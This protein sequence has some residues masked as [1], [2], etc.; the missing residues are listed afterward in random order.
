MD[1]HKTGI[2]SAA[3]ASVCCVGPLLLAVLGLGGL[4][5][6]AFIGEYHW[7]FIGGATA[8]LAFSWATFLRERRRC[9]SE[10]CEM[11]NGRLTRVTLPLAT[12]AVVGF[13][14]LNAYTYAETGTTSD[15]TVAMVSDQSEAI[16]PVQG[17]T[18]F[19]CTIAVEGSL[20]DLQGVGEVNASVPG[21][22]VTVRYD[23]DQVSVEELVAAVNETGYTAQMPTKE[24]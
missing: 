24:G 3:L 14:G 5:I 23:S 21:K 1:S 17:M 20:S 18:C 11:V 15:T 10:Q 7:Y 4:G 12:V 13:M 8:V 22:S 19:T 16:I 9:A 6:S 2:I